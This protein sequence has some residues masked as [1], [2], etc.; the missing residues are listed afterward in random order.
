MVRMM[1]DTL[2]R[3]YHV[4]FCIPSVLSGIAAWVYI[5]CD[6]QSIANIIYLF[7]QTF[8]RKIM[9][10]MSREEIDVLIEN[11]TYIIWGLLS[12]WN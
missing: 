5:I 2:Q 8:R 7:F 6:W 9:T 10:K 1:K 11:N 4:A 12:Q 3:L